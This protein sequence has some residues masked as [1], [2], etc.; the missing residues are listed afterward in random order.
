MAHDALSLHVKGLL[1]DGENIPAPSGLEDIMEN[2]EYSDAVAILV[3]TVSEAK[4]RS[5]RVNI[6]VPEDMLRRIDAIAKKE[7]CPDHPFWLMPLKM[8]SHLS[9]TTGH[10]SIFVTGYRD[11]LKQQ[12]FGNNPVDDTPVQSKSRG[13]ARVRWIEGLVHLPNHSLVLVMHSNPEPQ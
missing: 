9:R 13:A 8:L 7:V 4:P 1:E 11:N 10:C 2:P 3:V 12:L 5:V 6:T